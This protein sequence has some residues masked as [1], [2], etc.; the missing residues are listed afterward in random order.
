MKRRVVIT[1][2]GI[3]APNG[4]GL[5][6]FRRAMFQ[7]VSGLRHLPELEALGFRCQ[8]GGLPQVSEE[9]L[10]K[11]FTKIDLRGLLSTG[12]I[13]GTLAGMEAWA[14]AELPL[15]DPE[16]PD[17]DSGIIFGTSILG[18]DKFR[19]SMLKIDA[20]NVRRLG[21]TAVPQTMSSGISAF[22]GGKIGCGNQVSSNS[23]ACST[24]TEAILMGMDRIQ[25]GKAERMLAG[26]CGDSG[27]YVWGGFD[28][29]RVVPS[30]FNQTP[31]RASRPLSAT[32]SGFVPSS[33]AGA[34]VLESLDSAL[35]RNAPIY[36][37]V[38]GGATNCGGQRS[39]GSMT[40]SNGKAV[41]RCI[42][43]AL[44]IAGVASGEVDVINGHL[45]A[46][47][48]DS[49]EVLNWTEA[50]GLKGAE[51]P[52]LNSFKD[53]LGHGLSAS[54]SMECVAAVLQFA[55]NKIIGNRNA[56]DL[57]RE[58][59]RLIDPEKVPTENV[60]VAPNVIAKASLGFGDVNACVIFKRF[61][62]DSHEK[63]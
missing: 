27:P 52:Y 48:R 59:S 56:K 45:T 20:G 46:T 40:A 49:E 3:C 60:Q 47:S 15:A 57:H 29:M 18:V 13:Y 35:K 25:S 54:G 22:L 17:W 53:V 32:A 5:S 10:N 8:V 14:D 6:A 42:S 28:A 2:M 12:L 58:I 51:F 33:G 30:T 38:L 63:H 19:E 21:S 24:G 9:H 39:G 1:G 11:Y 61:D 26:S 23:S 16:N 7:G 43:D 37:E 55:E 50:L 34:L 41:Q 36:A 31:E 44:K 62:R 4:I